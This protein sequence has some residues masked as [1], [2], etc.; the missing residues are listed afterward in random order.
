MTDLPFG[1][2]FCG[3][4]W[5]GVNTSHCIRCHETFSSVGN[6]DAHQKGSVCLNPEKLKFERLKKGGGTWGTPMPPEMLQR[7]TQEVG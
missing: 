4:R 7:F 3:S 6:F 5:S 1:C 2:R